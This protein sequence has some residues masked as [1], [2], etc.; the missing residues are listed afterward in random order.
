MKLFGTSG[1]RKKVSEFPADFS[2]NLGKALGTFSRDKRIAIGRDTRASSPQLEEEVVQ[3]ILSTGK[4][5]VKLG[6][7]P[8][9]SVQ[10]MVEHSEAAGGII[11]TASHNPAEWNGLKF[12]NSEGVFFSETEN[13]DLWNSVDNKSYSFSKSQ[14]IIGIEKN[15]N[16]I[17]YHIN[18]IF[19]L[20]L[21]SDKD[22]LYSIRQKRF[23]VVVD[24]VNASGSIAIPVLLKQLGC[25]VIELYCDCSGL[26][27]HLPEPVPENLN[28]LAKTVKNN[29]ADLGIAV[30][31][32]ADR[33]VLIDE[34][35]SPIGEEK[36]IV[37]SAEAVLQLRGKREVVR[38]LHGARCL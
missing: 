4:E 23:K 2:E 8:T 26:F 18:S 31:P 9:P 24:A 28:E 16:A 35:G 38:Q 14:E 1:I 33:L 12:I 17:D 29:K 13:S 5:V 20:P 19:N 22:A 21:F 25:E 7:V 15:Y 10:L 34:K 36:T 30:D 3:G 11:I 37:L 32:D 27:P 6:I